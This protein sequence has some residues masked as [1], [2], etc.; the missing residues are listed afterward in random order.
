MAPPPSTQLQCFVCGDLT[1]KR[2]GNCKD[3]CYCSKKCQKQDWFF[4]RKL[5]QSWCELEKRPSKDHYRGIFFPVDGPPRFIWKEHWDKTCLSFEQEEYLGETGESCGL[6]RFHLDQR[7]LKFDLGITYRPHVEGD[8]LPSNAGLDR[9]MKDVSGHVF[10][11]P[12]I[13][14]AHRLPTPKEEKKYGTEDPL[15]CDVGTNALAPLLAGF[16]NRALYCALG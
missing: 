5:C 11:G 1:T 12:F 6:D 4:H 8:G 13:V 14:F 10:Y 16:R 3:A 2:C 15:P 9:L 7:K